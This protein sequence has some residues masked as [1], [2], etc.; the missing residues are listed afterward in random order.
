MSSLPTQKVSS[1]PHAPP[2]SEVYGVSISQMASA[3]RAESRKMTNGISGINRGLGNT[4]NRT[5]TSSYHISLFKE[6]YETELQPNF[7]IFV[8]RPASISSSKPF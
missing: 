3:I 5:L 6:G 7:P 4:E 2:K 8:N 1:T